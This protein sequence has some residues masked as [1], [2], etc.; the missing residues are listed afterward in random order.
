VVVGGE[1]AGAEIAT[2]DDHR[3]A[4]SFAMAGLVTPGVR[5]LDPHCV[6]K[7]FPN[8]WRVWESLYENA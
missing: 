2:Y 7:S 6:E 1:P 4:M 3:I 5:I 8:F